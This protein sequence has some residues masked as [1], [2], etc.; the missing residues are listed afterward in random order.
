MKRIIGNNINGKPLPPFPFFVP[1]IECSEGIP[2]SDIH[3]NL[4][5]IDQS[6]SYIA[7]SGITYQ[8]VKYL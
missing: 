4:S 2:D 7:S 1:P 5:Y 8:E 3:I 6:D